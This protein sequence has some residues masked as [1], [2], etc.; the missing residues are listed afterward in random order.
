MSGSHQVASC[1]VRASFQKYHTFIHVSW[2]R[3]V[4]S[5]SRTHATS[6]RVSKL[7]GYYVSEMSQIHMRV[8]NLM[9]HLNITNWRTTASQNFTHSYV[10]HNMHVSKS[11]TYIIQAPGSKLKGHYVSET[12]VCKVEADLTD[13]ADCF[14]VCL[15]VYMFI[16][17][18]VR[19]CVREY[20]WRC[21]R[22]GECAVWGVRKCKLILSEPRF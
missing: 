6:R 1:Y 14:E 2:T 21:A 13:I 7:K 17:M 4:I 8:T 5:T 19:A 11:R 3:W 9:W 15:Y 20:G 22:V 10:C 16:C 12:S 18:C